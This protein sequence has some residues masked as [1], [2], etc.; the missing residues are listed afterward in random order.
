MLIFPDEQKMLLFIL[1]R[2]QGR[3]GSI[4]F[5]KNS[6]QSKASASVTANRK[7]LF[8]IKKFPNII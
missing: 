3:F 7:I 6:C 1:E 2:K 8:K 5:Q 4:I